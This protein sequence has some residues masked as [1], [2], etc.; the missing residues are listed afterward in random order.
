MR[1][2]IYVR[3][4]TAEQ[5]QEGYSIGE[6]TERLTAFAAAMSWTIVR[7]CTDPGYSGAKME[8]PGLKELIRSVKAHETDKVLVYKLDRL[9]RS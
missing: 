6:Q 8:R 2:I 3:V 1:V 4:S 7:T 5:A 9:S